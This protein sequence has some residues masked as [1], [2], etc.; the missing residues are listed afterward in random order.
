MKNNCDLNKYFYN[1][2][3]YYINNIGD[4]TIKIYNFFIF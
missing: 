1:T 4:I 3:N 2:T